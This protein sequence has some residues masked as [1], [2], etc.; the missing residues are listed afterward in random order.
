MAL[1]EFEGKDAEEAINKAAAAL[2]VPPEYLRFTIIS[3]GS[4]GFLGLGSQK[5]KILVDTDSS[6][7]DHPMGATH[8]DPAPK[9]EETPDSL[10][11]PLRNAD[12]SQAATEPSPKGQ[13]QTAPI[14]PDRSPKG[15][16]G[17]AAEPGEQVFAG[18]FAGQGEAQGALPP[19]TNSSP[20]IS[21]PSLVPKAGGGGGEGPQ[22]SEGGGSGEGAEGTEGTEGVKD[23]ERTADSP[24]PALFRE[25]DSGGFQASD[26]AGLSYLVFPKEPIE[27]PRPL[28]K[29]SLPE[30]PLEGLLGELAHTARDELLELL[31]YP[32]DVAMKAYKDR[33]ILDILIPGSSLIIGR[34]GVGLDALELILNKLM[35]RKGIL[36]GHSRV[37]VDSEDYRARRHLGIIQKSFVMANEALKT[38]K[39]QGIPQLTARERQLV[40]LAVG[41]VEG[42]GTRTL[43]GGALRNIQLLPGEKDR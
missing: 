37:L 21:K 8:G 3:T 35:K 9:A 13:E 19:D 26:F 41:Q 16:A 36:D 12:T 34:R 39:P 2:R 18:S 32:S 42:I 28:T 23:P 7:K 22:D 40:R 4:K 31:G 15:E 20:G 17:E 1:V 10:D 24:I 43:G 33:V 38:G 25:W 29:P 30:E 11:G 27:L 5:A 14:G 6:G